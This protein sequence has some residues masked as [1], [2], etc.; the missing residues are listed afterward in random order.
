MA[1]N[2]ISKMMDMTTSLNRGVEV[3]D[4]SPNMTNKLIAKLFAVCMAELTSI[5][6]VFQVKNPKTMPETNIS[7]SP[8]ELYP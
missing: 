4:L 2:I 6:F 7:T 8:K 1:H 5:P 3:V